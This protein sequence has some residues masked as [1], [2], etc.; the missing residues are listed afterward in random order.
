[1]LDLSR[2]KSEVLRRRQSFCNTDPHP[3]GA[4]NLCLYTGGTLQITINELRVKA[5]GG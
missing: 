2:L 3:P 1:M 5:S 4:V